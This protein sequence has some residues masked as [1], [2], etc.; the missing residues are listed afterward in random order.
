MAGSS[1]HDRLTQDIVGFYAKQLAAHGNRITPDHICYFTDA[2]VAKDRAEA[3][4]EYSP[5]YLYFVHTL[6]HHGSLEKASQAKGTGY[7]SSSS[8]DYIKPE[9]RVG[10]G[11]DREG[12]MKT[13]PADIERW[14][15]DAAAAIA[16]A[17]HCAEPFVQRLRVLSERVQRGL[18]A[19]ALPLAR[20][21]APGISRSAA[22]A[23]APSLASTLG[24][25]R[26]TRRPAGRRARSSASSAWPSSQWAC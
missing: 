9:N 26:C 20:L 3:I 21:G 19:E 13:T 8:Y 14:L 10:A 22:A 2:Y 24:G 11:V 12:M 6:W 18:R 16:Q 1:T 15:I 23:L 7:L 5:F 17:Q 4:K 25:G